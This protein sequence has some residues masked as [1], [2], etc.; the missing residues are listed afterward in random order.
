MTA[1]TPPTLQ[2]GVLRVGADGAGTLLLG[3]L[4][5]GRGSLK[6]GDGGLPG[7]LQAGR[8]MAGATTATPELEKTLEHKKQLNHQFKQIL[9]QYIIFK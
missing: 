8:V 2:P 4:A 1:A 3:E 6:I 7:R 9:R 5:S